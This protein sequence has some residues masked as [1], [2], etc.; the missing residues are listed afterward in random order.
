[1]CPGHGPKRHIIFKIYKLIMTRYLSISRGIPAAKGAGDDN[2]HLLVLKI[3]SVVVLHTMELG[4][5][6][7]PK[8]IVDDVGIVTR[9]SCLS[10][11][12][13]G[14]FNTTLVVFTEDTSCVTHQPRGGE[15]ERGE[16]REREGGERRGRGEREEKGEVA[17]KG[18]VRRER[19]GRRKYVGKRGGR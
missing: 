10:G 6:D 7:T 5:K 15:R 3:P 2:K 1:M 8:N 4:R 11:I 9:A 13:D 17:G 14:G 19:V 12:E 16:G 18:N